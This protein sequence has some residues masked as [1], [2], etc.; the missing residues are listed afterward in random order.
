MASAVAEI[1]E[2]F[3][4][5]KEEDQEMKL[6]NLISAI[7]LNKGLTLEK[8]NAY[9]FCNRRLT[10]SELGNRYQ[11]HEERKASNVPSIKVGTT[12]KHYNMSI[13]I[14]TFYRKQYTIN[15]VHIIFVS[16]LK[17]RRPPGEEKMSPSIANYDE[18]NPHCSGI[19][20][21]TDRESNTE[22]YV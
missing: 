4:T 12:I 5:G 21:E 7:L 17:E 11:A 2:K 9:T 16:L 22:I 19:L 13:Y 15:L 10:L 20:T 3:K 18:S 14:K 6:K 1:M 8:E